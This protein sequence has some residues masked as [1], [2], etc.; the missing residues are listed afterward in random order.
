[1]IDKNRK[2]AGRTI[3]EWEKL[4]AEL[5]QDMAGAPENTEPLSAKELRW[6]RSVLG[7]SKPKGKT[8]QPGK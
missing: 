7:D 4:S 5:D 3:R 1:M 6:F 8:P 2:V